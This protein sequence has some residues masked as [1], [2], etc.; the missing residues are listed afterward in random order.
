MPK[1][2]RFL[3]TKN[4]IEDKISTLIPN[5]NHMTKYNNPFGKEEIPTE[6]KVKEMVERGLVVPDTSTRVTGTQVDKL[7]NET[8]GDVVSYK[9]LASLLRDKAITPEDAKALLWLEANRRSGRPRRTH[10]NR[11]LVVAFSEIKAEIR[12]I[13]FA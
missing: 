5:N 6:S 4:K 12:S 7:P 9:P 3:I 1:A 8:A 11:L 2:T 13:I 10:V